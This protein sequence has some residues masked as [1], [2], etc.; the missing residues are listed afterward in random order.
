MGLVYRHTATGLCTISQW[1]MCDSIGWWRMQHVI[2]F[3][4]AGKCTFLLSVVVSLSKSSYLGILA[5]IIKR[6]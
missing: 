3:P 1:E 4:L 2:E 6:S 5:G